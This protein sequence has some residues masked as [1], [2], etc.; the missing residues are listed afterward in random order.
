[1]VAVCCY[2]SPHSTR[3]LAESLNKVT[4]QVT[5]LQYHPMLNC[6]YFPTACTLMDLSSSSQDPISSSGQDTTS[7]GQDTT[8]SG[9]DTISSDQDTTTSGKETTTSGQELS[10]CQDDFSCGQETIS[11]D[12]DL[13]PFQ[14]HSSSCVEDLSTNHHPLTSPFGHSSPHQHSMSYHH[15]S[16]SKRY[17]SLSPAKLN[18]HL[19]QLQLHRLPY[20]KRH[21]SVSPTKCRRQL[22]LGTSSPISSQ[23]NYSHAAHDT[24]KQPS[25]HTSQQLFIAS[26]NKPKGYQQHTH[27]HALGSSPSK[28]NRKEQPQHSPITSLRKPRVH[29]SARVQKQSRHI[30]RLHS[31]SMD[32]PQHAKQATQQNTI[33]RGHLPSS[34]SI[35]SLSAISSSSGQ[36]QLH[37]TPRRKR[38]LTTT[39]QSITNFFRSAISHKH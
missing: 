10:P 14:D 7:S 13:F 23:Q 19:Q 34:C 1:M 4:I 8:S 18:G 35:S 28:P 6:F 9:Q 5:N 37:F 16:R 2:P 31:P 39:D 25:K 21:H 20:M 24:Q 33:M 32:G 29:K 30:A 22:L 12:Q 17:H 27:R 11:F 26:P 3:K 38:P 15:L 36:Q